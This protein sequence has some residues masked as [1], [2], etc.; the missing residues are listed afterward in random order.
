MIDVLFMKNSDVFRV[1]RIQSIPL[2]EADANENT[3]R[4]ATDELSVT[5]KYNLIA[6]E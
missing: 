5:D 6:A 1:N 3:K 2:Q 4:M